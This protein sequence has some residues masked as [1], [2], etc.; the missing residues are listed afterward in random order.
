MKLSERMDECTQR[1][2]ARR[3]LEKQNCPTNPEGSSSKLYFMFPLY[4]RKK[5]SVKQTFNKKSIYTTAFKAF[6]ITNMQM[7]PLNNPR[8]K[9]R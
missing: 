2:T 9:S 4:Y 8:K 1:K 3:E 5:Q 6:R 7:A